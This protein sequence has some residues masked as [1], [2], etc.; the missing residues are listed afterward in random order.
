M[1]EGHGGHILYLHKHILQSENLQFVC[2]KGT[3]DTELT[4][5]REGEFVGSEDDNVEEINIFDGQDNRITFEQVGDDD[6]VREAVRIK[7]RLI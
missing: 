4:L 6:N 5:T 2:S 7:T 3:E 1:F